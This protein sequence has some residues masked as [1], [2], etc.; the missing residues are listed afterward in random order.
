VDEFFGSSPARL[1]GYSPGGLDVNG[2]KRLR[3]ALN[4]K[5]DRIHNTVGAGQRSRD[6]RLVVNVGFYGLKVRI[7]STRQGIPRIRMPRRDPNGK[8]A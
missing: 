8:S 6:R 2:M 7:L 5:T 3:S 1:N 4:V